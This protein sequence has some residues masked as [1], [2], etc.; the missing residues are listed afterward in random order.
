[1]IIDKLI[2]HDFGVY[3]GYH[4]IELA[5][6]SDRAPLVLFGGLNGA[7]KTTLLDALQ[8]SLYGQV[9]RCS[10]RNGKGYPEFLAGCINKN[11]AQQEALIGIDFRHTTNGKEVAYAIR[12]SWRA[13]GK[14]VAEEFGVS[15]DGLPSKTISNNW[16][17]HIE[18]IIPANIA[19]LFFFDGEQAENYIVEG[20]ASGLIETAIMNLLG[21]DI[22]H[23]LD[24]DLKTLERRRAIKELDTEKASSVEQYEK[25]IQELWQ[26]IDRLHQKNAW[27]QTYE[28]DPTQRE[29]ADIEKQFKKVGGDLYDRRAEI[30]SSV[31]SLRDELENCEENLRKLAEGSLPFGIVINLLTALEKRDQREQLALKDKVVYENLVSAKNKIETRLAKKI[32]DSELRDV[33][34]KV[35]DEEILMRNKSAS[36]EVANPMEEHTRIDLRKLLS[37]LNGTVNETVTSMLTLQK[38]LKEKLDDASMEWAGVPKSSEV[39]A[40]LKKREELEASIKQAKTEKEEVTSRIVAATEEMVLAEEQLKTLLTEVAEKKIENEEQRRLLEHSAKARNTLDYF[41]R[42]VVAKHIGHIQSLVL[43]NYQS[44]LRKQSLIADVSIDPESFIVQLR[45]NEGRLIPP[46]R[47]SAGERQLFAVSLLWGMAKASGRPLPT[48]IDT[49]LGR[50]DA[51]HRDLMVKRYFPHASHQVLLFS[52]DQEVSGEY[53]EALKK[54]VGRSYRL[55]YD[56]KTSTTKI[57]EGYLQ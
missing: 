14:G 9:A 20:K 11:A 2:L 1:M 18:E 54:S 21:L 4:E 6:V 36:V 24:V 34:N 7:G 25:S 42:E 3:G 40:I 53:Y 52:T 5:P 55:E 57:M 41:R 50:L 10:N 17:Q 8:L 13:R 26:E 16:L 38:S 48:V 27:I 47:L 45:D 15:I 23:Q 35:I 32:S 39:E 33:V 28:I 56:D 49:P 31:E 30:E 43:E 46:E 51:T 44:L 12:R 19:H 22:V 37:E 29:L